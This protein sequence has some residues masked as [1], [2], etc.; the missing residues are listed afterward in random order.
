FAVPL[1]VYVA[2]DTIYHDVQYFGWMNR[3]NKAVFPE[4]PKRFRRWMFAG[5]LYATVAVALYF[6]MP[7]YFAWGEAVSLTILMFV[8]YLY[9]LDGHIWRFRKSPDLGGILS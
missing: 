2:C 3:Y 5:Y 6:L 7:E 1:I 4:Q 8:L 9:Y